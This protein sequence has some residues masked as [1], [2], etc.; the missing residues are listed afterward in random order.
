[1]YTIESIDGGVCSAT[2]F[3]ADGIHIGLKKEGAKDLAFIYSDTPCV[4]ASV[5]TTNTT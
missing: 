4:I 1:M 2:G 5:F 3:F